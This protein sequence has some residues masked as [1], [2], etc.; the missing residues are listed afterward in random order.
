M[1]DRIPDEGFSTNLLESDAFVCGSLAMARDIDITIGRITIGLKSPD[2]F[3]S[4]ASWKDV[5]IWTLEKSSESPQLI[6]CLRADNE[7]EFEKNILKVD[8]SGEM[9][10]VVNVA[11]SAK[12]FGVSSFHIV[13]QKDAGDAI[14]NFLIEGKYGFPKSFSNAF[15]HCSSRWKSD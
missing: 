10:S 14:S 6:R 12:E 7:K 3:Y 4:S 8:N 2:I 13:V 5:A 11:V 9:I 15:R 1:V